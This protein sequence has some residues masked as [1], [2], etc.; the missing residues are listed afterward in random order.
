MTVSAAVVTLLQLAKWGSLIPD[1]RGPHAVMVLSLL[2]VILW[3]VA[4]EP[5]FARPMI[6][7]YAAGWI[8]VATSASGVYG[9]ARAMLPQNVTQTDPIRPTTNRLV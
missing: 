4:N 9:F 7:G 3:G 6:W 5:T 1:N 2:G 8:A